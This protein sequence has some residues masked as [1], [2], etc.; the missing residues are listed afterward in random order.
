[1]MPDTSAPRRGATRC[2]RRIGASPRQPCARQSLHCCTGLPSASRSA[3]TS[4]T[5]SRP[6]TGERSL[7]T[8][9][10]APRGEARGATRWGAH[11]T[12][13]TGS[14]A[15][16]PTAARHLGPHAAP[17]RTTARL[18][19]TSHCRRRKTAPRK[20]SRISFHRSLGHLPGLSDDYSGVGGGANRAFPN[21]SHTHQKDNGRANGG[22]SESTG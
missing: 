10:P 15:P 9:Q 5:A 1:L 20:H 16:A 3:H 18:A 22:V 7:R 6:P 8:R 11:C 21:T 19:P 13:L 12:R 17:A 14:P 4:A 2:D